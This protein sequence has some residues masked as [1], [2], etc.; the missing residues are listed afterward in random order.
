MLLNTRG[1][2]EVRICCTI[3]GLNKGIPKNATLLDTVDFKTYSSLDKFNLKKDTVADFWNSRFMRDFRLRMLKGEYIK[4]CKDCF[5]LEDK[6]LTSKRLTRN[7]VFF[8]NMKKEGVF[9]KCQ[10]SKG[11]LNAMPRWWEVRLSTKCNVSCYMCSPVLSSKI[12]REFM[13][14]RDRIEKDDASRAEALV[15]FYEKKNPF[16]SE[17]DFFKQQFFKNI[18][19]ITHFEMRGG[20]VLFDKKSVEFLTKVSLHPRAQDMHFDLSTNGTILTESII[21]SLNRFKSGKIRFSIDGYG[22]ENEYMRYPTKWSV[23]E[24]TLIK[25]KALKEDLIKLIQVT[26]NVF[27]VYTIHKLLWYVDSFI[28]EQKSNFSFSFSLVRDTPHLVHELVPLQLRQESADKVKNFL[29]ESYMCNIHQQKRAHRKI[30]QGL[31]QTILSETSPSNDA[32]ELFFNKIPP[33]DKIRGQNYLEV[34]P[35]LNVLKD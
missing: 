32:K 33:L 22:R 26:V 27:Q 31:I 10:T 11:Y 34:F 29:N 23:V 12:Y 14:N 18:N 8:E 6:G 3:S 19:F 28:K 7:K 2:G 25:S 13:D 21:A 4:N 17:S 35:H 16:L 9:E 5:R 15:K 30:I 24:N 1:H 20:E